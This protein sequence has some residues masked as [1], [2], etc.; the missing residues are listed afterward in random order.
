MRHFVLFP[1]QTT[2]RWDHI[3]SQSSVPASPLLTAHW[4]YHELNCLRKK[5]KK[6]TQ[7]EKSDM[8]QDAVADRVTIKSSPKKRK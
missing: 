8:P 7:H 4:S 6:K 5:K 1:H 3:N 2:E